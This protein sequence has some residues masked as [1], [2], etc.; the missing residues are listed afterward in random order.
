MVEATERLSQELAAI[1]TQ[2]RRVT[3]QVQDHRNGT[4]SGVIW[5]QTGV[6]VTNA[7]V[8]QGNSAQVELFDGRT[9][10][11]TVIARNLQRDLAALQVN[12]TDLPVATIGDS[13]RLQVGELV[14]AMG[15]PLGV[16][17][18]LTTGII[19]NLG[20]PEFSQRSW[21][22]ADIRLAPGNSGG[23]LTNVRGEVI[24]INTMIVNDRGFAIPSNGIQ[25]FLQQGSR[26]PYL[27]VSV[28]PVQVLIRGRRA[29][30]LL[31]TAV[32][33]GSPADSARL[34]LGDIL[35]GVRGRLFA[36]PDHLSRI[37]ENSSEGDGLLLDVLRGD[38]QIIAEIILCSKD[39][40]AQAA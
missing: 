1:A 12:L 27:G 26:R 22:Q 15:N 30:G 25:Q 14:L 39:S 4:G 2:L 13:D 9:A 29:F 36:R 17:G 28:Q 24:G 16:A 32:E 33:P 8:V 34:Q 7:H 19:H 31:A 3:V 6:I 18:A 21:V 23:P 35:I 38:R 11:A 40:E 37:L 5:N 20:S 10:R